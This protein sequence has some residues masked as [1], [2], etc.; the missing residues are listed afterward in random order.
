[1]QIKTHALLFALALPGAVGA[2]RSADTL[3]LIGRSAIVAGFGLTGARD[4]TVTTGQVQTHTNG[5]IASLAFKH[6]VR[7]AVAVEIGAGLLNADESVSRGHVRTNA[8][9]PIL[10]GVSIS[11]P[12]LALSR[13]LRPYISGSAGP[14]LHAVSELNG[15]N[16]STTT[17]SVPGGRVALGANWFVS[18]HFIMNLEGDYHA[19]AKFDH[20][21]AVTS[22]PS[23]FGMSFGLGFAWG[24]RN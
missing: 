11:P 10:F 20:P 17:E 2:Q 18:R 1:M 9:I 5:G 21:D 19:V 4:A 13:A 12:E 3:N 16:E 15:L 23:G 22:K 7:P 24:G 14:Y 6:W 8:V